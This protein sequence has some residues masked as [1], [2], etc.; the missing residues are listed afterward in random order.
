MTEPENPTVHFSL[1]GRWWRIPLAT[2]DGVRKSARAF[3][4]ECLG[5]SDEHA[6][7]RA[8]LAEQVL[9]AAGAAR[10]NQG[11]D[12]YVAIDL[13]EGASAPVSMFTSWP[14]IASPV[15]RA[16][17]FSTAI[18]EWART[19]AEE[20]PRAEV[21]AWEVDGYGVIRVVEVIDDAAEQAALSDLGRVDAAYWVLD[22]A[23][24]RQLVLAFTTPV[25]EAP[26]EFVFLCDAIVTTLS[27]TI[28]SEETA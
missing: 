18:D 7:L 25:V 26:V 8:E 5:R 13:G 16:K 12:F 17:P 4:R 2:E 21:E 28:A 3:A 14:A 1:P 27:W 20:N 22:Q 24:E 11:E 23:W 10:R 6:S 19:L 9:L 15:L